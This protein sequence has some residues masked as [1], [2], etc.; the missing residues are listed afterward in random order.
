M[1]CRKRGYLGLE[2]V[3]GKQSSLEEDSI[4]IIGARS[5]ISFC[6][7]PIGQDIVIP[8]PNCF[9]EKIPD[10]NQKTRIQQDYSYYQPQPAVQ[11]HRQQFSHNRIIQQASYKNDYD[12]DK[13]VAHGMIRSGTPT[14]EKKATPIIPLENN[15]YSR[16]KPT[17]S[18]S[19]FLR[20]G[21]SVMKKIS[22]FPDLQ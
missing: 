16:K 5:P 21:T 14:L 2:P 12:R 11:N 3:H 20:K 15:S 1:G 17:D 13:G 18:S 7:S 9:I 19:T 10:H 8:N 4:K 22:S 6:V